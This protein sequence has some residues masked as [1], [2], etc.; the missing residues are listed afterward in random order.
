MKDLGK[1]LLAVALPVVANVLAQ[2]AV[3]W[4]DEVLGNKRQVIGQAEAD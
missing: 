1:L 3:Q 4:S 2:V